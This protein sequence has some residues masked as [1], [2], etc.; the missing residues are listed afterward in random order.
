M[1]M[2]EDDTAT[3][4]FTEAEQRIL[5][6]AG[7]Y[8]TAAR[9][10][11]VHTRIALEFAFRLLETENG[12]RE[13]VIPALI[14]H[15]VGYSM[16]PAELMHRA[17][18]P[19]AEEDVTRIHERE[20]AKIA[21]A[22]LHEIHYDGAKTAEILQII[23]GH[24]TRENALS[25][26]DQIVKDADK[27]TRYSRNFWLRAA[28]FHMTRQELSVRLEAFL[29]EW[30]FLAISRKIAREELRLRRTEVVNEGHNA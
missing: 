18:G 15:D 3:I 11:D 22:I 29:E 16:V 7:P 25:L 4:D 9:D 24:D 20:G 10:N 14:L 6:L 19:N 17:Y 26:N 27:L 1:I 13:V 28:E 12:H 8:L 5:S 23:D 30:F 21:A 2:C